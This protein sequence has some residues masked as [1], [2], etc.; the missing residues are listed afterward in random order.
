MTMKPK[1]Q[2]QVPQTS[3][4]LMCGVAGRRGVPGEC[5]LRRWDL[6]MEKSEEGMEL[7]S[8]KHLR[9]LEL[10]VECMR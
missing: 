7:D 8:Q 10:E 2:Q 6:G 9:T 4:N 1:L 5:E 3:K